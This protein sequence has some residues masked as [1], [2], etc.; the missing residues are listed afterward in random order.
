MEKQ[1]L[2]LFFAIVQRTD[3]KLVN[4]TIFPLTSQAK[5]EIQN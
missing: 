1:M 3:D 5:S 2:A 4:L